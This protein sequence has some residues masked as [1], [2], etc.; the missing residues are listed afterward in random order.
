MLVED[1]EIPHIWTI[2][3]ISDKIVVFLKDVC[4]KIIILQFEDKNYAC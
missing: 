2:T 3:G 4:S 1:I